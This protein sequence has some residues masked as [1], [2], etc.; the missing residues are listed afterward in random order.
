MDDLLVDLFSGRVVVTRMKGIEDRESLRRDL[1]ACVA[2]LLG[3]DVG[4]LQGLPFPRRQAR[5][6]AGHRA[7]GS[8][9][10]AISPSRSIAQ[11]TAMPES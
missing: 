9:N 10:E 7:L 6:P 2:E 1:E 11:Q 8:I 4:G 3:E 5:D